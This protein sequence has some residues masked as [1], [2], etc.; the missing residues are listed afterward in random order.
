MQLC[1][2][3]LQTGQTRVGIVV[4]DH[5]RFLD[6][7]DYLGMRS[8]SDVLHSDDPAAVAHDLI[9]DSARLVHFKDI[10]LLAPIDRQ[11][12]WAAG[13]TYKRSQEARERE[14]AGAARFYDLVYG[15]AR[16]ELF[17]K[18]TPN[19]VA[20]PGDRVR[21]R[22][23]SK[24]SVPEPELAVVLSPRLNIV[25]FTI[26]N[27]MSARDIE[28]DNPLYLPQAKVYDHSCALGPVITLANSMPPSDQVNIR[29]RIERR[30]SPVFEGS[31]SLGQMARPL[32][33][34]VQWLGRDNTFPAGV[35]LLTGT[36][37]VPPDDFALA[38]GDLVHIDITG[39]GRLT[40]YVEQAS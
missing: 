22:R 4:N 27:D 11:E 34:L 37:I 19:R 31:T 10:N 20:G 16:P 17:F 2:I 5:V 9:D 21:V 23:D 36:G 12:V 1:K 14:S 28:G 33:D 13:V 7:E 35:V 25:G 32:S 40:N 18:A 39:I 30:G 24:W 8:L 26:G 38:A 3:Q 29:L 6:M 15:A